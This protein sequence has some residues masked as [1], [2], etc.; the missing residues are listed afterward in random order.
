MECGRSYSLKT[1]LFT[2][3][4]RIVKI[5]DTVWW[6]RSLISFQNAEVLLLLMGV[7]VRPPWPQ[8]GRRRGGWGW[9]QGGDHNVNRRDGNLTNRERGGKSIQHFNY[10]PFFLLRLLGKP[11]PAF[12]K[13]IA[14]AKWVLII[15]DNTITIN[16]LLINIILKRGVIQTYG[17]GKD[18]PFPN[19]LGLSS[20]FCL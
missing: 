15:L 12:S 20:T 16:L 9:R 10:S 3:I 6:N 1:A 13:P 5:G 8:Y 14:L 2:E 19:F 11:L 17:Q 18:T 7:Q 4:D